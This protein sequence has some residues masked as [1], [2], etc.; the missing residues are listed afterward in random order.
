MKT[1][2]NLL[3]LV[4]L[5]AQFSFTWQANFLSA[6][7]RNFALD[8]RQSRF[9]RFK[10]LR[11]RN[12]YSKLTSTD[13]EPNQ[14]F[15]EVLES[16]KKGE[17]S[18]LEEN[19]SS[20]NSYKRDNQPVTGNEGLLLDGIGNSL[21]SNRVE[22]T[23][24]SKSDSLPTEKPNEESEM[25]FLMNKPIQESNSLGIPIKSDN[26]SP[27]S[28]NMESLCR[29][30]ERKI[31]MSKRND[32]SNYKFSSS[33][34]RIEEGE[35]IRISST[36]KE[37]R[38]KL[39][40]IKKNKGYGVSKLYL[41]ENS[42]HIRFE[43]RDSISSM[44]LILHVDKTSK[45]DYLS[46]VLSVRSYSWMTIVFHDNFSQ[47]RE[48]IKNIASDQQL[49]P[50]SIG[51]KK[52]DLTN[53]ESTNETITPMNTDSIEELFLH[54]NEEMDYKDPIE[55]LLTMFPNLKKLWI[56][57]PGILSSFEIENQEL[58]SL[59]IKCGK[60]ENKTKFMK[61]LKKGKSKSPY[62]NIIE[63]DKGSS[64]RNGGL[65]KYFVEILAGIG[66]ILLIF[67]PR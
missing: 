23:S 45:L 36:P 3:F 50:S 44:S 27:F 35:S 60:F 46:I 47:N 43:K 6:I 61:Q 53:E 20:Y 7:K 15:D 49:K 63:S 52:L 5:L 19:N 13:D 28:P 57:V 11:R 34:I 26:V 24:Q 21:P 22:G 40:D 42:V 9:H 14:K 2:L 67:I 33:D 39:E 10:G 32:E 58:E 38:L 25:P 66:E 55:K 29:K 30:L 37:L 59:Y 1:N 17:E 12:A 56:F 18:I 48:S 16:K 8:D 64:N 31:E 65:R 4:A 51:L 54:F 62:L 41:T